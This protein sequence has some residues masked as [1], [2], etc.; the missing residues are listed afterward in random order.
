MWTYAILVL[1]M[2]IAVDLTR[3]QVCGDVTYWR[4]N[5]QTCSARAVCADVFN[6]VRKGNGGQNCTKKR[7]L[8]NCV[9]QSGACP[10][11]NDDH[12]LFASEFHSLFVNS[13]GAA[14]LRPLHPTDRLPS[15]GPVAF[16][17]EQQSPDFFGSTF[18]RVDCR[19]PR[20]HRPSSGN[21]IVHNSVKTVGRK[22]NARK[23]YHQTSHACQNSAA[24][25][26][27]IDPCAA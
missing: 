2:S 8:H 4:N 10:V 7:T 12:R 5:N 18:Q 20:H 27:F 23:K 25:S 21:G 22:Y 26:L 17:T 13:R 3:G 15:Q 19:C 16:T 14:I 1:L 6:S 9:C 24:D 11:D